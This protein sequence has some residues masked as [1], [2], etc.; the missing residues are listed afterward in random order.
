VL[1]VADRATK[2]AVLAAAQAGASGCLVRPFTPA[3]LEARIAR[4]S[5]GRTAIA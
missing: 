4:I 5:E 2:E 3:A 1:L